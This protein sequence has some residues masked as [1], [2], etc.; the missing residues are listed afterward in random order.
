M[1]KISNIKIFLFVLLFFLP[2]KINA[3]SYISDYINLEESVSFKTKELSMSLEFG[4]NRTNEHVIKGKIDPTT[5]DTYYYH[6]IIYYYNN[7]KENIKTIDG[8]D[9]AIYQEIY[10]NNERVTN[11]YNFESVI[12]SEEYVSIKYYKIFIEPSTKEVVDNYIKYGIKNNSIG[13]DDKKDDDTQ[14]IY[15]ISELDNLLKNSEYYLDNYDINIVVNENNSLDIE[16][17]I[18]AYFNEYKHGIYRKIPLKNNITRLDGTTSS[19]KVKISN[20]KVDNNYSTSRENN[21]KIIKIGSSDETFIGEKNY[22]INYTY[23]LGKDTGNEYDELYF[24]IIGAE[25][26]T[27]IRN[28]SFTISMPKEFDT[29]K[30][31][32]S[33]GSVGT[34]GSDN[35]SYE[36]DENVIKGSY[37]GYLNPYEALTIRIELPEGYFIYNDFN[38]DYLLIIIPIMFLL[39]SF[40]IWYKFGKDDKVIETV[41]FYPPEGFNSAEIGFLYRGRAENKDVT[42]LLVFLANK[43]YIEINNKNQDLNSEKINLNPDLKNSINNKIIEL[44]NKINEE[45]INNP[46]SKKIKYY[47]NIL[48]I[49]K[50]IDTPIDY[51]QYGVKPS[52]NRLNRKNSFLIRKL[53]DYDGTNINEQWFMDGLFEYDRTEVTDKMLYNNFYITNNRILGNVNNKQ[54]KD[55][56]FEKSPLSKKIV[57]ILMLIATFCLITIP[58]I[59]AYGQMENLIS[60]VLFPVIGFSVSFGILF[61]KTSISN[62]IFWLIWGLGFGVMPLLSMILPIIM[63]DKLYLVD[64]IVGVV[65]ISGMLLC[66]MNLSKRTKYG[67]EMLGKIRGF[68]R[69]LETA[70]K[71]KLEA[72]VM[73]NPTYFYD[74]L[75]YAYVLGVSDKWI[76]KF[77]SILLQAPSWYGSYSSFDVSS[78]GTFMKTTMIISQSAMSSDPTR[79][80]SSSSGSSSS[81]SSGGGS[82]GGGSGGGGGGSW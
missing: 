79:S 3:K 36:V 31:G 74:I 54:N 15:K 33:S 27:Y 24:N 43:G 49:Y 37:N 78:F 7:F 11:Y 1:K 64:C 80:S 63:Q 8:Y 40:I 26:D 47:E 19:N 48:D 12:S 28:I 21:Y 35:V 72:M 34:I 32:F 51:K 42:S 20:I 6:Y 5:K 9:M 39:I 58:P 44:Q 60:G 70:E 13:I 25:W 29:S 81:G 41:E 67:N 10:S 71:D 76:K 4:L 82:S 57:I 17:K 56:I 23:S 55:K 14:I 18:G 59:Y 66:L 68:K 62:K 45:R 38:C 16:E 2:L 30:I 65:C 22:K 46:T 53:K 77:E 69:F 73:D 75:P 61:S 50:N 52:I